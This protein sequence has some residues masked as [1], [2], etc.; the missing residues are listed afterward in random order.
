MGVSRDVDPLP[1][2]P[3]Q[4]AFDQELRKILAEM[5]EVFD[6]NAEVEHARDLALTEL[7]K[8]IALR[9]Q[10]ILNCKPRVPKHCFQKMVDS[11]KS[12][13]SN[14]IEIHGPSIPFS[15]DPCDKQLA[16]V[17]APKPEISDSASVDGQSATSSGKRSFQ[18][19]PHEF[20]FLVNTKSVWSV[21]KAG[22][23]INLLV[24]LLLSQSGG[25]SW[26]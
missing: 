11:T 17:E 25:Y 4:E 13:V 21:C 2:P 3:L 1:Q 20:R 24:R 7:R 12:S 16:P 18:M 10:E 9:W 8:C 26:V 14:I 15:I 23:R 19:V 5:P 22:L 6:D